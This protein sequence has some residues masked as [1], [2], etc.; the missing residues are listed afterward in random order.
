VN[1]DELELASDELAV[2]LLPGKGCDV[3]RL[4]DR[5]S[6]VDVLFKTPWGK[7]PPRSAAAGSSSEERWMHAYA[8]GWQLVVPN[9]G[10]ECEERGARWGFHGEAALAEW[11]VLHAG[12]DRAVLETRLTTVPLH[13]R[14]SFVVEG[15]VLHLEETLSNESPTPVEVMWS[16]HPAF[17]PPFLDAGCVLA[18]GCSTVEAD[19]LDPGALLEPGS[20]HRWP[21]VTTPAGEPLDL[22]RLP[23]PRDE[24]AVLCYLGGFGETA[25]GATGGWFAVT[26]PRLGLG[27]G[28]CWPLELF[29]HAWLWEEVHAGPGWP[30]FKRAYV[31]AVEPASTIPGHG[32]VHARARGQRGVLLPGGGSRTAVIDTV[33]FAGVGAVAGIA[34]GGEVRA[35]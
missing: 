25:P 29:P 21:V 12:G 24:R 15:P 7:R 23:G 34:P 27:V 9:G 28:M 1:G 10:D 16:H 22:S 5:R 20:R 13:L 2:A 4:V 31:V 18:A 33:V 3:Y 11:E 19:D 26:N 32:I 35:I 30:W 6:G 8:G 17:G 14:R